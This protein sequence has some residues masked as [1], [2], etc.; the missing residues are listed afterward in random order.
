[1]ASEQYSV[2]TELLEFDIP[3]QP[4]AAA[5][6]RFMTRSGVTFIVDSKVIGA[7]KSGALRGTFSSDAALQFLLEGTGLDRR[8]IGQGVYTLV[9]SLPDTEARRLP[10][11]INYSAAVQQAVM[12]ALCRQDETRPTGYRTVIRLWLY[13]K[14]TTKQ[15]EVAVSTGSPSRDVAIADV[16][17]RVE[18]GMPVPSNLPQ[19]IKLAIVP[20]TTDDAICSSIPGRA[21]PVLGRAAPQPAGVVP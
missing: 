20:Q 18:I 19:P 14:G 6:E 13:P 7:R 2:S 4:L 5:L 8:Q 1:L 15:V 16:L 11:F 10:R 9:P 17:R 21:A 12:A 3:E